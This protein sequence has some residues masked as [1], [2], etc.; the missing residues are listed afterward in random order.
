MSKTREYTYEQIAARVRYDPASGRCYRVKKTCHGEA[1]SEIVG[2]INSV[3]Y[4]VL[5]LFNRP[6][7][8]HRIAY[9][10]QTGSWPEIEIDHINRVKT[11]N[12]WQNLRAASGS[13]NMANTPGRPY[14]TL[15]KGVST[16]GKSTYK[17]MISV[18]NRVRYLGCF[19]TVE[20]ARA[21][22]LSAQAAIYGEFGS[23]D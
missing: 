9:M 21:A 5:N 16:A 12:R 10:L 3:G 7:L 23:P 13:Q 2:T 15:P 4:R 6:M 22:Y 14:R 20:S 18:G 17:A 19:N 1:G 11:D 8:V